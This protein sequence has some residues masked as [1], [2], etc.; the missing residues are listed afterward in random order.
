MLSEQFS[1]KKNFVINCRLI[2]EEIF[3]LLCFCPLVIFQRLYRI[4]IQCSSIHLLLTAI[5]CSVFMRLF[6]F[7]QLDCAR[8]MIAE[9]N[10][11]VFRFREAIKWLHEKIARWL[12]QSS[13][14]GHNDDVNSPLSTRSRRSNKVTLGTINQWINHRTME[15]QLRCVERLELN[16]YIWECEKGGR[17][18]WVVQSNINYLFS[19]RCCCFVDFFLLPVILS[20]D[21]SS[22]APS[23]EQVANVF[24]GFRFKQC[25]MSMRELCFAEKH[26]TIQR[27]FLIVHGNGRLRGNFSG[28]FAILSAKLK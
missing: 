11:F 18:R 28:L 10:S 27:K 15:E 9:F 22:L 6:K 1:Q 23:F 2:I 19:S 24:V 4:D 7:L 14:L 3:K 16:I 25:L 5:V 12:A 21:I 13:R 17:R 26:F 8:Q 20:G